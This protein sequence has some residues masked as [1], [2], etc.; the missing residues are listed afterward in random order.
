MSIQENQEKSEN[1]VFHNEIG[2]GLLMVC[3]LNNPEPI[4]FFSSIYFSRFW[5]KGRL[6]HSSRRE[7]Q[8]KTVVSK[9]AFSTKNWVWTVDDVRLK[10]P[11]L[12][13][14]FSKRKSYVMV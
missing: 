12:I 13:S 3:D 10:N 2:C 5:L 6:M 8:E 7:D 11:E 4:S 1:G 9:K 14:F